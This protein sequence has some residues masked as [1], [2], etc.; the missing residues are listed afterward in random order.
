MTI[1]TILGC[2]IPVIPIQIVGQPHKVELMEFSEP[3]IIEAF[4]GLNH[5]IM[6]KPIAVVVKPIRFIFPF[7]FG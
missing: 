3:T 2:N 7:C 1:H 6:T 4:R 5:G